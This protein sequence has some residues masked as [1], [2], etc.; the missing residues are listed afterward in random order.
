MG[1]LRFMGAAAAA[2]ALGACAK[3]PEPAA[4]EA[5]L[6]L[7]CAAFAD[8]SAAS[9]AARF[10]AANMREETLPGP[11][12]DEY[13]ATVV[14]PEDRE[15]RLEIVWADPTARARVAQ[16]SISGEQ[17]GWRG[18]AGVALGM[19]ADEVAASNGG[20]FTIAGFGWDLGGWV[21][22]WKGGVLSHASCHVGMRL[23]PRGDYS[24]A[25]GDKPFASDSAEIRLADPR[26]LSISLG[27][28]RE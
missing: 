23:S 17:S 25:V 22:D 28:H 14:Y 2:L 15:R 26:V 9:L 27:Y 11:E 1:A 21:G 18:P 5:P 24:G 3:A 12:G 7:V 16:V 13:Q 8:T 10:G 19:S 4:P 6:E 20:P